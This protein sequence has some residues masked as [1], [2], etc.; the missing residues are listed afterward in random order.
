MG[1][2]LKLLIP[3]LIL[4]LLVFS[5]GFLGNFLAKQGIL[6]ILYI[7]IVIALSLLVYSFFIT[8]L[9]LK[10]LKSIIRITQKSQF[11]PEDIA[12]FRAEWRQATALLVSRIR[13]INSK[14]HSMESVIASLQEN[15]TQVNNSLNN[16]SDEFLESTT[17]N[18]IITGKMVYQKNS[19]EESAGNSLEMSRLWQELK[20]LIDL[21]VQI[22]DNSSTAINQMIVAVSGISRTTERVSG[23]ADQL[24]TMSGDGDELI[25]K[26]VTSIA[27]IAETYNEFHEMV[28]VISEIA[29][30]TDILSINAAIEAAQAGDY[31]KGFSVVADEIGNLA[32]QTAINTREITGKLEQNTDAINRTVRISTDAGNRFKEIYN[33]VSELAGL[34]KDIDNSTK[35]Q[36]LSGKHLSDS[37]TLLNER[38]AQLKQSSSAMKEKVD[39][40]IEQMATLK[41]VAK[42]T[43]DASGMMERS[44]NGL[45]NKLNNFVMLVDKSS[46]CINTITSIKDSFNQSF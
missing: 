11:A 21:Q 33:K 42:E 19:I 17:L 36:D 26:S 45:Q 41:G 9:V 34:I 18:G 16:V 14:C 10:P 6:F 4:V 30:R 25:D 13:D 2:R 43:M 31:G 23:W 39:Q 28:S 1:I 8:R 40:F 7:I 44:M 20:T 38:T 24:L 3:F 12:P 22:V 29:S 32:E 35:A 46:D 5:C 15:H 37:L 27:G